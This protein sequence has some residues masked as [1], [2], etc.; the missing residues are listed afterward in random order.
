[1]TVFTVIQLLKRIL[2]KTQKLILN[3]SQMLISIGTMKTVSTMIRLLKPNPRTNL[4][5]RLDKSQ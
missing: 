4:K 2:S 3:M 5:L 1:M